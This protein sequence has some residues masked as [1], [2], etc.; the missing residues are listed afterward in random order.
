V[1]PSAGAK[2]P[3]S[4]PPRPDFGPAECTGLVWAPWAILIRVSAGACVP[5]G[6]SLSLAVCLC[7]LRIPGP[8]DVGGLTWCQL[9]LGMLHLERLRR[10]CGGHCS[11]LF[12][13]PSP[14]SSPFFPFLLYSSTNRPV[15]TA[16]VAVVLCSSVL[17]LS[18][19]S[20]YLQFASIT[21]V[22]SFPA[23]GRLISGI[24]QTD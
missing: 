13:L 23:L 6:P 19:R 3:F 20:V 7:L 24:E 10:C 2:I 21:L 11:P 8:D 4:Q 5:A 17:G 9:S 22:N 12:I 16:V 18:L 1:Q 15:S 14:P